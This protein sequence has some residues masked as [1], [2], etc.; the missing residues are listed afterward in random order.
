MAQPGWLSVY[1]Q[2]LGVRVT[3]RLRGVVSVHVGQRQEAQPLVTECMSGQVA[4]APF[5]AP[6]AVGPDGF[7]GL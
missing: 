3:Q 1:A 2:Q 6:Q 4:E 7:P 5:W